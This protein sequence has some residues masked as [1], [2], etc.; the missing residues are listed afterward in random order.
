MVVKMNCPEV[1]WC[2]LEFPDDE[3][4]ARNVW[5]YGK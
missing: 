4:M 2:L 3:K 5:M 1:L